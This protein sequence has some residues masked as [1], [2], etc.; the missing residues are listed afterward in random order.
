M[1]EN[2]VK[3]KIKKLKER[4]FESSLNQMHIESENWFFDNYNKW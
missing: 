2:I 4:E 3:E 1:K